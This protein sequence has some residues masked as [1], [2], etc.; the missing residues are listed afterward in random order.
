MDDIIIQKRISGLR[1][2][3][4][5]NFPTL[6]K[7]REVICEGYNYNLLSIEDLKYLQTFPK[8]YIM[9]DNFNT[10]WAQLGNSVT[11]NVIKQ[12]IR[13]LLNN[14]IGG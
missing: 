7:T 8:E 9:D 10:S 3:D 1:F 4:Y 5:N 13:H 6:C 12:L 2:Y 11:V 14:K